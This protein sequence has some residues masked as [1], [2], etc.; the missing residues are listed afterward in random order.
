M[1]AFCADTANVDT[2]FVL[3][4]YCGMKNVTITLDEKV[5]RWARIRAAEL[6]TSVSRLV[7]DLLR[8]KML[9]EQ[10]Y[11]TAME[12]F[13]S[14]EPVKLKKPGAGYPRRDKLHAR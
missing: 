7:G 6:D 1:V 4:Y 14:V 2:I 9:Q 11:E 8:E 13:L 3:H 10:A 12:E 5:A